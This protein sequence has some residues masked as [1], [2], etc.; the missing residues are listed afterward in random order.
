MSG[1][2]FIS[3]SSSSALYPINFGLLH[4]NEHKGL[5]YLYSI[6]YI[7]KVC[8]ILSFFLADVLLQVTKPRICT[9]CLISQ[10]FVIAVEMVRNQER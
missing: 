10:E 3:F 7:F 2:D 9:V 4:Y 8:S 1:Q 5:S 6:K